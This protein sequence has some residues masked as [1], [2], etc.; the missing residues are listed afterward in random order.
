[1]MDRRYVVR[2]FDPSFQPRLALAMIK[3][4]TPVE[5]SRIVQTMPKPLY[6]DREL[7]LD[8]IYLEAN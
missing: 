8:F 1:M 7:H 5:L 6:A 4:D 2:F 3:G